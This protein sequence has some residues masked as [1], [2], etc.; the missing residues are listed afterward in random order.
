MQKVFWI[1]TTKNFFITSAN[2]F[3]LVEP[4]IECAFVPITIHNYSRVR[5]FRDGGRNSEYHD[6]LVNGEV[7]FFAESAGKMAGSI[8]ATI[9]NTKV[10]T[11]AKA[12]MKL[13]PQEALIHDIVTGESFRGLGV[14]PFMLGKIASALLGEYGIRKIIVDVNIRNRPSLRMMDKAGLRAKEQM[15]YVSAFGK[16]A[17]QRSLQ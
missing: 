17:L 14:G 1:Y 5:E 12:Y 8:W 10:E 7:G 3:K 11:V 15:L 6:K 9:N 2:D 13:L 4:A 16:L